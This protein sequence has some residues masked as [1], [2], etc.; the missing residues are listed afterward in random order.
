MATS[1]TQTRTY[2]DIN[3]VSMLVHLLCYIVIV[4]YN[5]HLYYNGK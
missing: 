2:F 1:D 3:T 4:R 5:I